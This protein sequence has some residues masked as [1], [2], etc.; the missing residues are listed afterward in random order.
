MPNLGKMIVETF[1]ELS[2]HLLY[3][4]PPYIPQH[5]THLYPNTHPIPITLTHTYDIHIEDAL[6]RTIAAT[7]S[8]PTPA[9]ACMQT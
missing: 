2:E 7:P 9:A 1:V 5:P 6:R 8:K 3:V 4:H